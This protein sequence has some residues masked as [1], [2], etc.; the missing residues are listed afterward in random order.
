[1]PRHGATSCHITDPRPPQGCLD[2]VLLGAEGGVAGVRRM[3]FNVHRVLR[4]GGRYVLVTNGEPEVRVPYLELNGF[5]V[6][7]ARPLLLVAL[8]N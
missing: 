2:T 5:V 7:H 6:Q 8:D 1:M 4:D 3:L